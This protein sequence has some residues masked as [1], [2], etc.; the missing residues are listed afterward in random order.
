MNN[1]TKKTIKKILK[2]LSVCFSIGGLTINALKFFSASVI[3]IPS[4][5]LFAVPAVAVLCIFAFKMIRTFDLEEL[6]NAVENL[7]VSDLTIEQLLEL[8]TI[9]SKLSSTGSS[10]SNCPV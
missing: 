2:I 1:Q 6:K 10:A 8:E 7:D 3:F 9:K 4:Y 5:A